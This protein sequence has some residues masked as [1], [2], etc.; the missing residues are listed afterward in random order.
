MHDS[1]RFV[2]KGDK[3]LVFNMYA[4]LRDKLHAYDEER[5]PWIVRY[6]DAVWTDKDKV[7]ARFC[8]LFVLPLLATAGIVLGVVL[9]GLGCI[10]CIAF[11]AVCQVTHTAFTSRASTV[12][13]LEPTT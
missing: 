11:A 5:V 13:H 9:V 12:H 10:E 3:E 8:A 6:L 7:C 4:A 1:T 2:G